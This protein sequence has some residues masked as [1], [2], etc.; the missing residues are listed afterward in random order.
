MQVSIGVRWVVDVV[1]DEASHGS[2]IWVSHYH[3]YCSFVI[4]QVLLTSI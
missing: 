4:G 1:Q 3:Y 2:I